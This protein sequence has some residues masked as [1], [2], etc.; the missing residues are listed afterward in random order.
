[1]TKLSCLFLLLL[2]LAI[3]TL[4][5]SNYAVLTGA[6]VDA[7]HLPVAGAAV[8]LTAAS[9]GAIRRLVSNQQGLFEA[10]ALLPDDYTLKVEASGFAT[11][12]QSLRLEVGQKLAVDIALKV[13]SVTEGVKVIGGDEALQ[14]TDA[15]VGEVVEPT[16]VRELPLNGRMLID[17]VLTVPG[18]HVGFGAQTGSTNPL[19]WRPGERSA[20]VI[21]GAR[22]NANFFLL[23]GATNTDPTFNTQNLSPSPDAVKE[24]RVETSSYTADMG[25]AGGGQINIVT[26]SGSSQYHG[27]AYEF[28]RNGA[29][30]ASTFASMGNNHLVQ[31]NFGAAFGGPLTKKNTFFFVNYE[32]LRLAQADAQVLTVP[33]AAEI[34]GDFSMSGVNIYDPTT[35]VANPNFNPAKP[36]GANNFPYTRTQFPGNVIPA[37]RINPALEAFLLQYVPMPN[38]AMGS[39]PDSNNYLDVRNETHFQDQGTVRIDHNFSKGDTLFGRYSIGQEDGFSPSS[40]VTATT[41]NLPGF[42]VNF[43]NR[44]QQAAISWNHI[45]AANKVNTVSIAVSRLSMDRTSQN[46]AVN[47]IVGQLGI[48]GVGFG[49]PNAWGAPWFAAQGYT[50]IGDT[51]AATPMHAW[52][53]MYEIRDTYAWEKGRHSIKFGG[54]FHWYTWPMW[55]FFQNRGFYQYT[56]GYTTEFGF[57]N[58]T[59]SGLASLLLSL[60]AVKQRQAGVP[61]MNLRNWGADGFAEDSWKATSTTTVSLGLR[62]EYASPLYDKDNTNTNLIFNNGVPSVFVG[63]QNGY[64]QGLMYANQHNFAPRLGIAK[65]LPNHGLVFHAAYG[66]FFTPVDLN[67]WCNQRHNVPYVFPETQQADNF[68]PPPALF[69]SGMNFG[70]PVLG[71]GTLPATTVSF[72]AFDPHSPAQYV[73]QWNASVQKSLDAN[74]SVEVGY[75]GSRGF[76]LQRAHLINN[77]LPGPGPLG[78]RRPF[79]TLTFVPNTTLPPGSTNAVIQSQTVPVSTIN[80]L[81]N[82]AQSW[83]DAGYINLRRRYSRGLSF[84]ANYTYSKNLTNAP[85]FRSPMDE[86]SIPQNN[87]DLAAEKGPGCDVRHRFALSAVYAIPAYH[88]AE[89]TRMV[90]Q[91]WTFSTIYQVQSGMPF[92][93]SV[94]GDTANS[95][96]VLGENPIRANVTGQPA[97]GPG[98][99]TA[100]EWFNPAAFA[101]PPAFTFGNAGRNSVYGPGLQTVDIALQRAFRLTERLNFQFRGEAFNALNQ[102]NLGTPNRFVNTPQ[103]GTITMAMTPG[104]EIQLSARLSF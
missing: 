90:T 92:T 9:T 101:A 40:G 95:G 42:G 14:T 89:W 75:I 99:H 38:M 61:Q 54:D 96:T 57:N 19:Y 82:S 2:A 10:P 50:G 48:Q 74:T 37:N 79:K 1:M 76:H 25:G 77:T 51:F 81:E 62:Y 80:L 49:G 33:T 46:D 16:S 103:F 8:Q 27:T 21:G 45:F 100:V 86:S 69:A 85:D 18:T 53:T 78:P 104:R 34:Q 22:P 64:P 71:T 83:Y 72:T 30:D 24:F 39:G 17:L 70:T 3:P 35:A 59:G 94:F 66:I 60:P 58:G 26:H 32:G 7:Q 98:T 44:S 67:T 4:G 12:T 93:I 52:D 41:E 47:N 65:N 68:T 102:V 28:L 88:R 5:Q 73:Q 55:G 84:L 43:D 13:G 20:V 29:M 11:T 31:N 23:D 63:G 97:F 87:N 56:T 6:I 91:N 36:T 15:S